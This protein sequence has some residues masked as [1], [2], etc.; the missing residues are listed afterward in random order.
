MHREIHSPANVIALAT[1]FLAA[2]ALAQ[3]SVR[4]PELPLYQSFQPNA[5]QSSFVHLGPFAGNADVGVG[6][7]F[8][9]NANTTETNKISLNEIDEKVDLDLAWV[10]SPFN[11]IDLSLGGELEENFYS[12]GTNALNPVILPG[13]EIRLQA[14]VGD[15]VLQAFEQFSI[16][17]DPVSDPSVAGQTN[18]NRV[19][20][21]IGMSALATWSR[22]D[23]SLEFDYTYSDTL[24]GSGS[25]SASNIS[26]QEGGVLRN[27]FHLGSRLGFEALPNL[28]YGLQADASHNAGG[29]SND[30][31][32]LSGG[33]FLRGHV[34]S[35]LAVDAGAGILV[36]SGSGVGGPGYYAYISARH[37]FSHT[38]R[39][40]L[41]ISHDTEFSSGLG[42]STENDFHFTAEVDLSRR[43]TVSVGPFLNFGNEIIGV[44]PGSYTQYGIAADSSFALSKRLVA[45][46]SYRFAKREGE[47]QEGQAGVNVN[48]NGGSGSYT[49]NLFS[50]TLTYRF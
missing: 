31:N 7:L 10:L 17:Q 41:G 3:Q 47:G 44:L 9:D 13:S 4:T 19:A 12:N 46:I 30:F 1:F 29:G 32:V 35:L 23:F 26:E 50:F 45:A 14:K 48:Q 27:S 40:L 28:S 8:T 34:T 49:Q 43:W 21:T 42:L 2:S 38:F 6:Y 36:G 24:G 16:I 37:E 20:N 25:A 33:G 39:M 11:R 5:A 22:V 18:L 15:V